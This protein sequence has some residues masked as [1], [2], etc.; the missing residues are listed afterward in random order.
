MSKKPGAGDE[1]S[2]RYAGSAMAAYV[3]EYNDDSLLAEKRRLGAAPGA[4]IN[5]APGAMHRML[6]PTVE[7]IKDDPDLYVRGK[8]YVTIVETMSFSPLDLEKSA[9]QDTVSLL[10]LPTKEIVPISQA[11]MQLIIS[12]NVSIQTH[13]SANFNPAN[14]GQLKRIDPPK[15]LVQSVL[16]SGVKRGRYLQEILTGPT[17]RPDGCIVS[18]PGYDVAGFFLELAPGLDICNVGSTLEEAKDAYARLEQVFSSFEFAPQSAE[19]GTA[20]LIS[21]VMGFVAG[22]GLNF[23]M[24]IHAIVAPEQESGKSTASQYP[25]VIAYGRTCGT[26]KLK[27]R[28]DSLNDELTT[29][30]EAMIASGK[31]TMYIDNWPEG[32]SFGTAQLANATTR[33]TVEIRPYGQ[34]IDTLM[35]CDRLNTVVT[36]NQFTLSENATL[37]RRILVLHMTPARDRSKC[38]GGGQM[39]TALE[40][41]ARPEVRGPILRDVLTVLRAYLLD[42]PPLENP[43]TLASF[44]KWDRY[45]RRA[46]LW[47]GGPDIIL[48]N[49]RMREDYKRDVEKPAINFFEAWYALKGG[50]PTPLAA[51]RTDTTPPSFYDALRAFCPRAV[52]TD[53][54]NRSQVVGINAMVLAHRLSRY[55]MKVRPIGGYKVGKEDGKGDGNKTLFRVECLEAVQTAVALSP[56]EYLQARIRQ[57]EADLQSKREEL[58]KLERGEPPY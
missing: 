4:C 28:A 35:K 6:P 44:D 33:K 41:I 34:N 2:A 38:P 32:V 47:V 43:D 24:P 1:K 20:Y 15:T 29:I 23:R 11:T 54:S 17:I 45:I 51:L 55:A 8:E 53:A 37:E 7:A 10:D 26:T 49:V 40:Q 21:M 22:P 48:A 52:I 9:G 5:H 39:E 25:H 42:K 56:K 14:P 19:Y 18:A 30:A 58:E 27:E 50:E 12:R 3:S 36:A 31:R 57:L 13:Q 46:I 16:V